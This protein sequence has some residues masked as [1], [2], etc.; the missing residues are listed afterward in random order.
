MPLITETNS[1]WMVLFVKSKQNAVLV[2]SVG[3]NLNVLASV[4][5]GTANP[6]VSLCVYFSVQQDKIMVCPSV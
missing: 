1:I 3:P 4:N 2:P 5:S 6:Y